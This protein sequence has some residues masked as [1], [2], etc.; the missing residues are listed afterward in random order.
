M[1]DKF[2]R[3]LSAALA[4][5]QRLPD[6]GFVNQVRVAVALEEQLAASRKL[7]LERLA[8][9]VAGLAAVSLGL[10]V[11]ARSAVVTDWL[12]SAPAVALATAIAAVGLLVALISRPSEATSAGLA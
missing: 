6:R 9:Q 2:D 5:E 7:L 12:S 11:I 10:I 8:E 3:L 1:D 4:P